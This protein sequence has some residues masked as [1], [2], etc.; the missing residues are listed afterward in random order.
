MIRLMS[1]AVLAL[2]VSVAASSAEEVKGTVKSVDAT[3]NTIVVTVAGK[4]TTLPV[5]KDASVVTVTIVPGKKNKTTEKL[6]PIENGLTGVKA[7]ANVT[8]LTDKVED[9]DTVTSVKVSDGKAAVPPK[10]KKK[11]T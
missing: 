1:G 7:G 10:K 9:K 5:S 3:K 2:F 8:L 6:T 11:K 4:D